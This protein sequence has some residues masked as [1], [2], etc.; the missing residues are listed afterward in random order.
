MLSNFKSKVVLAFITMGIAICAS[1]AIAAYAQIGE[2]V[3]HVFDATLA[4][5]QGVQKYYLTQRA[6]QLENASSIVVGNPNFSAY[7]ARAFGD[8]S[9]ING[10]DTASLRDLISER[11]EDLNADIVAILDLSGK[12]VVE[13][14]N[15][16]IGALSLVGNSILE[17]AKKTDVAVSG[18]LVQG[19]RLSLITCTAIRRGADIQALLLTG[20]NIDTAVATEASQ[21]ANAGLVLVEKSGTTWQVVTSNVDERVNRQIPAAMQIAVVD[22][23]VGSIDGSQLL[24]SDSGVWI[25]RAI[26]LFG[27]D[28]SVQLVSLLPPSFRDSVVRAVG[29][30][31]VIAAAALLVLALIMSVIAW[32]RFGRPLDHL[33]YL[34]MLA[35]KGDHALEFKMKANG[36]VGRLASAFNYLMRELG[37]Y[38]VPGGTPMRR[39]TDRHVR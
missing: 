14:G 7:V 35:E 29:F 2:L 20:Q 19:K 10:I 23:A 39:V 24:D 13:N 11:R 18:F 27:S 1:L 21:L 16:Q 25:F 26:P 32:R 31:L 3:H 15:T 30:P 28:G 12:A 38:R 9:A 37:R 34:S 8:G 33:A 17:R 36:A 4:T 22:P 5:A 6:R